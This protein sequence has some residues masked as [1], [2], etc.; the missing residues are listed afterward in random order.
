[1]KTNSN[2][3]KLNLTIDIVMFVFLMA[4]TGIGFLIKYV[5]I[6]GFKRNDVYGKDVELY[7]WGIDRHQWG[8]IHL[9]LSFG[10]FILLLL[11][12]IFHWKQVV[13][14]FK[15]MVPAK[16]LQIVI[17]SGIIAISIL[18]GIMPLFV[19]PIVQHGLS[20]RTNHSEYAEKPV[21]SQLNTV[22]SNKTVNAHADEAIGVKPSP[23]D[24][25]KN[26]HRQEKE[27]S[28]ER[29]NEIEIYGYMTLNDVAAKYS[30]SVN[31]LAQFIQ[32]PEGNNNE[33]LGRLRKQYNFQISELRDYINQEE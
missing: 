26:K 10:L 16:A 17:T 29:N 33:K 6:P 20:H 23:N 3:T 31:E 12:I 24:N 19:K 18:L 30:I 13:F 8:S 28:H 21:D 15:R 4:I 32:I 5:L 22:A 11:H 7:F 25:D 14:I 1:M 2:K 27:N 9:Y